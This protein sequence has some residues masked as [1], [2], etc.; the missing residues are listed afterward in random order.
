MIKP[1]LNL[2]FPT[3]KS[4][5]FYSFLLFFV[6]SITNSMAQETLSSDELFINAR[7]AAFDEDDYP[8]AIRITKQALEISPDYSDIRIFLGRLYTWTDEVELARKEFDRVIKTNP[9]YEDAHLAYGYLEYWNDNPEKALEV[10]QPGIEK[11]PA[12]KGLLMLKA[13]IQNNLGQFTEANT[14]LGELLVFHPNYSEARAFSQTIKD[15][16]SKNQIGVDYDFVYFDERF[17]DPWHLGS[18][19]YGRRTPLGSVTGRLNYANR[20]TTNGVQ[21]EIDAYPRISD[22]FYAYVSGGISENGGIFPRYRA[23]FSLYANLPKSFEADVGFRFLSFSSSTWIYTASIGKYYSNYWFNL[24]TYLTPSN[25]SLSKSISLT[26]RYYLAGADD[27]LSLRIGTGLSPDRPE[28]YYLYN[29]DD[30]IIGSLDQEDLKSTNIFL[31]YRKSIKQS[32][33][34]FME[35]G[36]ENQEYALDKKGYQF[37]IGAGFTKRF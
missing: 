29:I 34:F 15:L 4:F 28:N 32:N 25:N 20:F 2:K 12:S 5:Q 10:I 14:T 23:G 33:I 17:S 1:L 37:T 30:E 24:R 27:Y 22:T 9:G 18:I 8:K 26:V 6:L 35:V 11:N 31:G 13:K 36:A 16:S 21:F 3:L 19:S 7:T